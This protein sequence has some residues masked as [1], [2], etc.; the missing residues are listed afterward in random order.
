MQQPNAGS[1]R[2]I[3]ALRWCPCASCIWLIHPAPIDHECNLRWWCFSFHQLA[4][5]LHL[6]SW[7][8]SPAATCA[9]SVFPRSTCT[10]SLPMNTEQSPTHSLRL[11]HDDYLPTQL[12]DSIAIICTRARSRYPN[13]AR[14]ERHAPFFFC[15]SP[16]G[17]L[18]KAILSPQCMSFAPG[19]GNKILIRLSLS[20]PVTV[21]KHGATS[22][23][24]GRE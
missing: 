17:S 6:H 2:A 1:T 19:Q 21:C 24:A 20:W 16:S 13:G 8:S 9:D 7:W 14:K 12:C 10:S 18:P 15:P 3:F 22:E 23:S 5:T 4:Q 11:A